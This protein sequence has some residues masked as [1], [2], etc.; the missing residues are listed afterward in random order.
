METYTALGHEVGRATRGALLSLTHR[1]R[2][3]LCLLVEGYTNHDIAQAL[4]ISLRTVECHRANMTSKLGVSARQDLFRV[5]LENGLLGET[6]ASD[7]QPRPVMANACRARVFLHTADLL[8]RESSNSRIDFARV[9]AVGEYVTTGDNAEWYQ[10][11]LVV[12]TPQSKEFDAEVFAFRTNRVE[13][14][15]EAYRN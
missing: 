3:V 1:E 12:H 10:V 15:Q 7:A 6:T 14:M 13:V 2:E 11:R 5:A 8:E 4:A 9:P